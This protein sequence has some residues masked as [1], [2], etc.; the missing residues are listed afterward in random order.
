MP[1][2]RKSTRPP[3][4]RQATLSFNNRVTKNVPRSGKDGIKKLVPS[5][6]PE[7]KIEHHV[8]DTTSIGES[9]PGEV[10]ALVVP[11]KSELEIKATILDDRA[12]QEYWKELESQRKAKRVHQDSLPMSE[13][14]LRYFD[15]SSQYGVSALICHNISTES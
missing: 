2:T 8:E 10:D 9:Q 1:A 7:P 14:I 5:V 3:G 4:G 13:K 6:K 11:D 15:V 12:I